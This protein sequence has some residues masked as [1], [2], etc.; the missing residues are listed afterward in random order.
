MFRL[1]F[2]FFS[3]IGT[4]VI[5]HIS[6]DGDKWVT[7]SEKRRVRTDSVSFHNAHSL[8]LLLRRMLWVDRCRKR[9]GASICQS[10]FNR[11]E[12]HW[13]SL[14][15]WRTFH[16][17]A[18]SHRVATSTSMLSSS[19]GQVKSGY[20]NDRCTNEFFYVHSIVFWSRSKYQT[21][22]RLSWRR[23]RWRKVKWASIQISREARQ[24][25]S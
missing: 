7:L 5:T 9:P 22:C 16:S 15:A 12:E 20:F 18:S 14:E 6:F 23:I 21:R 24:S 13:S 2:E 4:I 11:Q 19:H 1:S 3:I 10:H 25:C 8:L 17:T